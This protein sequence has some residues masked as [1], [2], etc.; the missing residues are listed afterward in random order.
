[1]SSEVRDQYYITTSIPYVNAPPH[2]G[3]ALE[4][5]QT[6]VFARYHR[7]LDHDTRF[8]TGTD[9]N[10]LKNV[11]AAEREGITTLELVSRNAQGFIDLLD[12]LHVENDD[13]IRTAVDT[14]HF[15]G[16][17]HFWKKLEANDDLYKKS[18]QGLYCVGCEQ[19]YAEDE[20]VDGL[21]PEHGV[22]PDLIEEENYFFRLSRYQDDLLE[23]IDSGRMRIIPESRRNEVRSFVARGL[24]DL[25]VSRSRERA[26]GWG[27]PVP[28]DDDQVMYVWVDALANYI[29]A[30]GYGQDT[31]LYDRYWTNSPDR[32]HCIGK[33]ILRFHAIYWPAMLLSAGES[34][35]TTVFVH[36]Y[37]TIAGGKISKSLGNTVDPVEL[38]D[39]YGADAVRYWLLR[40]VP[41]TL[42]ADY[43]NDK[44]ERRY[45]ADLANDLG[46]LLNRSVSMVGRYR[47]GT[48]PAAETTLDQSKELREAAEALPDRLHKAM[49]QDYDPQA[50]LA[51]I[52]ELVVR[53]N[54]YVEEMA[55]WAVAKEERNGDESATQKLD[56]TLG[57]L[58]ET[59]R[60][61][62]HGI[63][64][65]L[66]GAAGRMAQQLGFELC[67]S[68]WCDSLA[69]GAGPRGESVEKASPIFPR[70]E[71]ET[72]T[73]EA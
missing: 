5:V 52:N 19:F 57:H 69:W 73:E 30:L 66:P 10:S 51:A 17:E 55:P 35:P 26:R 43:T 23:F 46:N 25:S 16:A 3:H 22:R 29:T 68:G 28:D 24:D 27:V 60:V 8:L 40:E 38:C 11:Q 2:I 58:I 49:G 64:P 59:L 18:Y 1:M 53:A 39:A 7:L 50:A 37:L 70:I 21:C 44:L 6:D 61:T 48:I 4:M 42:D 41:P 62:C 54:R 56:E 34:L 13:F 12:L 20:L 72:E 31:D 63:R 33:G 36:G 14:R 32:V 9:E 65:F 71:T 67:D 15:S 45:N 47:K